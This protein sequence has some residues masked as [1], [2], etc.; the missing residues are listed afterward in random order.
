MYKHAD[1]E[2]HAAAAV[3]RVKKQT[4]PPSSFKPKVSQQEGCFTTHSNTLELLHY[5]VTTHWSA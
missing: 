4:E 1:C 5:Y 3:S 2:A